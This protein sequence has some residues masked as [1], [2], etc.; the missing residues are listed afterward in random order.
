[1][2]IDGAVI[3]VLNSKGGLRSQP[4]GSERGGRAGTQ[5]LGVHS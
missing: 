4:A 5:Q 3:E 1:M 2:R